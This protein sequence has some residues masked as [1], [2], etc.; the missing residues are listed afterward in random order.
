MYSIYPE[1]RKI[2]PVGIKHSQYQLSMRISLTLEHITII[3]WEVA[4][5]FLE[6]H[7][8]PPTSKKF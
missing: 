5:T 3:L 6:H 2:D 4:P 7:G 1:R 8:I